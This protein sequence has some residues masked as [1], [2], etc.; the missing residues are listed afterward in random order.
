M[1]KIYHLSF[2]MILLPFHWHNF[3][4][5]FWGAPSH[6]LP[7]LN[8][9]CHK[10]ELLPRA[11]LGWSSVLLFGNEPINLKLHWVTSMDNK[12]CEISISL[13]YIF[14]LKKC[15]DNRLF[16]FIQVF[17]NHISRTKKVASRSRWI[18]CEHLKKLWFD[19]KLLKLIP[20]G[21]MCK[22]SVFIPALAH[23]HAFANHQPELMTTK[24][25]NNL[26][27]T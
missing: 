25:N 24:L 12:I 11:L 14:T 22:T 17:R 1:K 3:W 26:L 21:Y 23:S 20:L 27:F 7:G 2:V 15:Q 8:R 4:H 19:S 5:Q 18:L 10:V 16:S 6:P 9:L 13:T